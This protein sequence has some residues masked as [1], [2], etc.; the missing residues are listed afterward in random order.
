VRLL[1]YLLPAVFV[2]A[3]AGAACPAIA[4]P[5][6]DVAATFNSFVA[7]QNAH[8]PK[9]VS[10]LLWDSNDFLWI[11]RGTAIFGRDAAMMRFQA[12]YAGTWSLAP[13]PPVVI[14][15]LTPATAQV[16]VPIDFTIGP[17][18]GPATTTRFLMNQTLVKTANGWVISSILPIPAA[19]PPAPQAK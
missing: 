9:A 12:L 17:P 8:D 2:F 16:F 6:D 11:T 15:L 18:G 7:A 14:T 3:L 10:A 5:R 19:P 4:S 1:R 13:V